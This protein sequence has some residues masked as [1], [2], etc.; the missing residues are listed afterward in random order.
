MTERARYVFSGKLSA[1]GNPWIALEPLNKHLSI[2]QKGFLGFD[3]PLGTTTQRAR[4][5]EQFLNDNLTFLTYTH[6]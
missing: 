5:I 2:L 1:N 3:L 6:D 4:E